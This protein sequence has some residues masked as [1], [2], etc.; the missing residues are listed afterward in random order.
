MNSNEKSNLLLALQ[1]GIVEVTFKKIDTEEIRVMPCTINPTVLQ[2]NGVAMTLNM[3]A[4][5]DHFVAWA[6]DKKAWRSFR[7]D[8]VISWEKK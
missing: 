7:L 3:S 6:L 2:D 8:T 1:Q 4:E 5:S